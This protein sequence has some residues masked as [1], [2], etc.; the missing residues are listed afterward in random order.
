[1]RIALSVLICCDADAQSFE[2]ADIRIN[3]SGESRRAGHP[4]RRHDEDAD[5]HRLERKP[6]APGAPLDVDQSRPMMRKLLQDRFHV[7][8][9]EEQKVMKV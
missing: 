3:K 5:R 7:V 4:P 1:M 2:V 9:H 8:V 6:R